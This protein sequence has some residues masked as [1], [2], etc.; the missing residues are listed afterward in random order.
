[1]SAAELVF[2]NLGDTLNQIGD[3]LSEADVHFFARSAGIFQHIV[4]KSGADSV[5]IQPQCGEFLRCLHAVRKVGFTG[6]PELSRVCFLR[7]M[8]APLQQSHL[9]VWVIVLNLAD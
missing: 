2:A 3:I 5:R 8:V 1:M 6:F 4:Q 9:R 7:E